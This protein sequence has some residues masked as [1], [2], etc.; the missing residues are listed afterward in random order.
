MSDHQAPATCPVCG[1]DKSY[2]QPPQRVGVAVW[3]SCG[4][5]WRSSGVACVSCGNATT[6]ALQQKAEIA[7]LRAQI[8]DAHLSIDTWAVETGRPVLPLGY[9]ID[10]RIHSALFPKA[11]TLQRGV[12]CPGPGV[13]FGGPPPGR[14]PDVAIQE[15][16]GEPYSPEELKAWKLKIATG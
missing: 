4:A 1:A 2:A 14:S 15:A 13:C 10:Q 16:E 12:Q 11:P 3:Y 5:S 8:E 9:S 6:V 7:D